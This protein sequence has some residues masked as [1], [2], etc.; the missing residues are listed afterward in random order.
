MSTIYELSSI[1]PAIDVDAKYGQIIGK[2]AAEYGVDII[3]I[4]DEIRSKIDSMTIGEAIN[5]ANWYFDAHNFAVYLSETYNVSIET[6]SG[7][8]SAVS[9]RMP[10]LRNKVVA[11]TILANLGSV[12]EF[13][14]ID[15]AKEL[16]LGL[17]ANIAMAIK[18]AR[19]ADIS[20]TLS[21]IKRRSFYNNIVA[22]NSDCDSVTVDTW[23][24]LAYANVTGTDKK[25]ALKFVTANEKALKGTGV[26][27]F[28]ISDAV[29]MVADEMGIKAHQIQALYWV[30]QAGDYNGGRTD[31]S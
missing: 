2:G 13:D 30:S 11:E 21:G 9:P 28:I 4:A 25:Q 6:A 3:M 12:A 1:A 22:P 31:I 19:G 18:I 24:M 8:I 27:Y 7:V 29:R 23:M 15:A 26:G 17:S 14:A 10:W 5:A 20:E 16:G